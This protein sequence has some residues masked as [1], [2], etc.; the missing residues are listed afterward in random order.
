MNSSAIEAARVAAEQFLLR[1]AAWDVAQS[2]YES[3]GDTF[4][5]PTPVENGALRRASMDLTRA[6]ARMRKP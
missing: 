5:N 3:N 1:L 2:T 4:T 6:L